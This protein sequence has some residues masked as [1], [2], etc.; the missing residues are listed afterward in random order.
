MTLQE[1]LRR[2]SARLVKAAIED[3]ALEAEVLLRHAL[4]LD[5]TQLYQRLR[6]ELPPEADSAY[7]ALLERRL[8]REPTAYITGRKE[9]YCLE[10]DVAAV[11]AVPR[12]ET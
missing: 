2:A 3:P 5:R 12:P 1:A 8:H 4:A 7:R 10:L 9:F 11:A 6:D